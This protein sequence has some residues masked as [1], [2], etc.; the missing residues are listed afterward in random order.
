MHIPFLITGRIA[1]RPLSSALSEKGR[2]TKETNGSHESSLHIVAGA[3]G[4][5]AAGAAAKQYSLGT[6][7][8]AIAG[9]IGGGI[10]GQLIGVVAGTAVEGWVGNFAGGAVGGAILMVLV[11][12]IKSATSKPA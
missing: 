7:G 6:L 8:N 4:G 12:F 3:I 10:V 11:G 1:R 2:F 5:S 9:A